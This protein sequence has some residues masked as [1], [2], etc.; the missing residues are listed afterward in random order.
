MTQVNTGGAVNDGTGDK[1]RTAFTLINGNFAE[2]VGNF[3][4]IDDAQGVV[5]ADLADIF[6][7][8]DNNEARLVALESWKAATDIALAARVT[9]SQ[10]NTTITALNTAITALE[11]RIYAL[12]H[13]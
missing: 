5:T 11:N 6:N 9:T 8:L 10:F 7:T 4:T 3:E 12:E 2:I 13:P 1:L